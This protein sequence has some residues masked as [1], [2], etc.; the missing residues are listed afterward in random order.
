[1]GGF[2]NMNYEQFFN[3]VK[4][5]INECNTQ[6]VTLGFL[7]DEFWNWAVKSLSN[8]TGKYNNEKLA[9][10]QADML[11]SWLEDTWRELKNG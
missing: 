10:K 1:M 2:K 11:L 5:W 6:A 7:T 8:L 3:D 4:S 9:M